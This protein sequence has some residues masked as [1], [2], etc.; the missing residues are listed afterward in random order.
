MKKNL[1]ITASDSNYGDFLI[2][3]WLNSVMENVKLDDI[4]IAVLDYGL[5]KSQ[6]FYLEKHGVTTKNCVKDGHVTILRYRDMKSF[7][8]PRNYNQVMT[9][10]G[11]DMIFQSD[12]SH[13]FNENKKSFRACCEDLKNSYDIFISRELFRYG[14]LASFKKVIL[15]KPQINGG[16]VI[17]PRSLMLKLCDAMLAV[18]IDNS[19]FGPDQLFLNYFLHTNDFSMLDPTYNFVVSSSLDEF[20]IKDYK[21]YSSD[22]KLITAVHNAGNLNFFRPISNFGYGKGRNI[23]KK[24]LLNAL[25]LLNRSNNRIKTSQAEMMSAKEKAISSIQSVYKESKK[26]FNNRSAEIK[27][28]IEDIKK[29]K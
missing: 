14:D 19:K 17:A 7:L 25:R 5:T 27:K 13:L 8:G 3:H 22:H 21:F 10:D 11:G 29:I 9:C 20:Y 26:L 4:D 18:I 2:E 28:T 12:I 6:K 1:I 15:K 16:L 23:L 24:D